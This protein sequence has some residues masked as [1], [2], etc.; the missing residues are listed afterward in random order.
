MKPTRTLAENMHWAEIA[1]LTRLA[2][3]AGNHSKQA[4][5]TQL[6]IPE[7][8]HLVT[9]TAGAGPTLVRKSVYGIVLNYLQSFYSARN[10]DDDFSEVLKLIEEFTNPKILCLFGLARR[11]STSEFFDLDPANDK[12]F[13]EVQEGL[14]KLLVR[15]MELTAGTKGT[16]MKIVCRCMGFN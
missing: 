16:P 11:S 5:H 13:L 3:V 14:T 6:Y 2:F 1:T 9:L 10:D 7:I 8:V 15:V 12:G 4:I